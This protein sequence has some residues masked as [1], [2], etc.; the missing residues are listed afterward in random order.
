MIESS[1][2][3]RALAHDGELEQATSDGGPQQG[4]TAAVDSY[5]DYNYNEK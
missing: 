3:E 2:S 1:N 4:F 5:L